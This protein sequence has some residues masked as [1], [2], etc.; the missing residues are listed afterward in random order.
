M[1]YTPDLTVEDLCELAT[2][3]HGTTIATIHALIDG[4]LCTHGDND[5]TCAAL[6]A[7]RDYHIP[8]LIE[9]SAA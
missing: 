1:P 9:D 8:R 6:Y 4:L 5:A 2:E 3:T 7:L